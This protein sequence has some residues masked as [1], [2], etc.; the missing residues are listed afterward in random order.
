MER[1]GRLEPEW[2]TRE[3]RMLAGGRLVVTV[4]SK[5]TQ[6]H[7]TLRF[8]CTRKEGDHWPTVPFAEAT[9]VYIEDYDGEDVAT[10]YPE[11]G[12]LWWAPG[13]TSAARWTVVNLLRC[14]TGYPSLR[15][16]AHIDVALECGRCGNELTH[17]ESIE[18][19]YGPVCWG[20][21]TR[22]RSVSVAA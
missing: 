8:R 10:Y 20:E 7:V 11:Q 1:I 21:A 19:G 3:G 14:L 16:V 9:H 4:T 17:P 2:D 5:L 13:A 15:A 12:N 18:R 22:G 6:R